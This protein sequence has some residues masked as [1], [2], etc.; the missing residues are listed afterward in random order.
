MYAGNLR[1]Y[2]SDVFNAPSGVLKHEFI[3]SLD[4][5]VRV[6]KS[7]FT[8]S[9]K[10]SFKDVLNRT[11]E[12]CH[13]FFNDAEFKPIDTESA[14][15]TSYIQADNVLLIIASPRS[16]D[17]ELNYDES[18]SGS[19]RFELIGV[20]YAVN[21]ISEKLK[22][23]FNEICVPHVRWHFVGEHG[24][25]F[26]DINIELSEKKNIK[27][28]FYPWLENGIESYLNSFISSKQSILLMAGAAGT[29]KTSLLRHFLFR[30]QNLGYL[31]HITYD[32]RIM[33]TDSTFIE[34]ITE[35]NPS[36]MIIEDADIL[37][38]SRE[39]DANKLMA[40][41]LN[42]SDGLI[43]LNNKKIV[44][45][46]NMTDFQ[47]IDSALIRPG[48]CFDFMKCRELSAEEAAIAAADIGAPAPG[49]ACTLAELFNN[50]KN[51]ELPRM[52]FN[53]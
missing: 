42:V 29:G 20:Y 4:K 38:T 16:M 23:I 3:S 6:V 22:T 8:F 46:T 7:S 10:L 27:D 5:K 2:N 43:P 32:E 11:L 47:R 1:A 51:I 28:S 39:S 48:R 13:D 41:F 35:N 31:A 49:R 24:T 18:Q 44:F 50:K 9:F 17:Q 36:I 19:W 25:D 21:A 34:F 12:T 37:L 26:K 45:T 33:Q 52:G 15:M 53:I 40:R 30:Y 14:T